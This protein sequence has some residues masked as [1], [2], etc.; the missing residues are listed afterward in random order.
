[1]SLSMKMKQSSKPTSPNVV[2]ESLNDARELLQKYESGRKVFS[3][4]R[5]KKAS[6]DVVQNLRQQLSS[7]PRPQNLWSPSESDIFRSSTPSNQCQT[8][9]YTNLNLQIK[10]KPESPN[11]NV[12]RKGIIETNPELDA[13]RAEIKHSFAM[14]DEVKDIHRVLFSFD[15]IGVCIDRKY[16]PLDSICARVLRNTIKWLNLVLFK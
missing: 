8:S 2:T 13:I 12:S 10:P 16:G 5:S 3:P 4:N 14:L 15:T 1:M 7:S 11:L 9:L 6:S